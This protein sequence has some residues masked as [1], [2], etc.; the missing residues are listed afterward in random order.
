MSENN[1]PKNNAIVI[2]LGVIAVVAIAGT[3]IY[4]GTM[5]KDDN[6]DTKMSNESSMKDEK[7]VSLGGAAM[8]ANKDIISNAVN[9]PNL[10]TLVTA[11]KAADL[12]A[13]LQGPGPFTVF[14]PDNNAFAK[15]PAGT[16]E[17]LVKPEN[18]ASLANILTYHV[19]SGK[20]LAK[21]LKDGQK[22]KTVQGQELTVKKGG[23]IV[24]LMDNSGN[25]ST[26]TTSDVLQSNGV[27]H[28]I[29]T[30]VIPA[31]ETK[32]GGAAMF[33]NKDI[34]SNVV[35]AHNLSTLVAA[36]KAADLVATLQGPGPF[37][38]FGPD[39][40]AF[41]KLPA[42]AVVNLLKPEN[43]AAL[44]KTL[45]YHAVAGKFLIADLKDGQK[46]KTVQGQELTVKK[47][48]S[49]TQIVDASGFT[50]TII[51]ADVLQSNGVAHVIDTVLTPKA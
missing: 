35:N 37:T 27:V 14:A 39:N 48:A 24:M 13:T 51:T 25:T 12:V 34:I 7:T 26:I 32:V 9:A 3:A 5:K 41:A 28:V 50:S 40:N 10:S 15:L 36:V 16:V 4:F 33:A 46:L 8:F 45:T 1:N 43:K 22:L 23:N 19:V 42:G 20:L 6:K 18:K 38:V 49:S 44:S 11:V 29:D 21:D 17:T 31:A 30:V 2:T 47:T